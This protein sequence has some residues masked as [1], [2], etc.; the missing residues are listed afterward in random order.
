[1]VRRRETWRRREKVKGCER[2]WEAA[3]A[4]GARIPHYW[5][6]RG[7]FGGLGIPQEVGPQVKGGWGGC[8]PL[9][10]LVGSVVMLKRMD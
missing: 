10:V 1:M 6:K 7:G 5:R 4:A 8:G 9:G 2:P 3:P